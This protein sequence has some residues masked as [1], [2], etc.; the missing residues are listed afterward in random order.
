MKKILSFVLTLVLLSSLSVTALAEKTGNVT[1]NG[2][3]QN[4]TTGDPSIDPDGDTDN[5]GSY[6]ITFDTAVNWYVTENSYP[7]I[8]NGVTTNPSNPNKI[9]NNSTSGTAVSVSLK[10]FKGDSVATSIAGQLTLNLT[11]DLAADGMG[12]TNLANAYNGTTNYT[13][14]LNPGASN[15]WTYGFT[16]NYSGTLSKTA[17]TPTYTMVLGFTFS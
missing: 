8:W 5:P 13:A 14:A 3:L 16:G 17:V 2:S 6:D 15:A 10:S 4:T 11:G 9:Q 12:A 7:A 1:V